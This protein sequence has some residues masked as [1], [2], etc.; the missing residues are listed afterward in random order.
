[1]KFSIVTVCLNSEKTIA[2]TL[3]SVAGQ[4]WPDREH[5]I[6]D[7][8]SVDQ[9]A[10][11]VQ[12]RSQ[13]RVRWFSEP[14]TGIYSA[15]NKG[16]ARADGDVIAFLNSDDVYIDPNVLL[17]V[18]DFFQKEKTDAVYGDLVYVNNAHPSRICRYWKAGL[19]QPGAFRKGW[20]IPHPTFFC[21]REV[22][23][24]LGGY[25]EDFQIAG[26]F[27]LLLRFVEIHRIRCVYLPQVL[28]K[29]RARG[30]A[31]RLKGI[32][33]GNREI[34]QSFR[35][36]SLQPAPLFFLRKAALKLNQFFQ[37]PSGGA[38]SGL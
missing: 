36:H 3:D 10:K 15:M 31:G 4:V 8:G 7:G 14:D 24:K 12:S 5:L 28:V 6:I 32:W 18:A 38:H 23:E 26:D 37:R 17:K 20:V 35:I 34:L 19:W 11:V 13:G 22:Y 9:T 1:M 30:R 25:R 27:E 33:R 2:D 21:R 29:M 16:L